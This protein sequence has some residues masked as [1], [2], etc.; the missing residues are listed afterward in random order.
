MK[1]IKTLS[2]GVVLG[3]GAMVSCQLQK[4]PAPA[5]KASL[6][7]TWWCNS[8]QVLPD[9]YFGADGD[10]KQR[11][12]GEIQNGRWRMSDDSKSILI[13]D[14][15]PKAEGTWSYGLKDVR[16]DQIVFTFYGA[17]NSFGKCQ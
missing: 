4:D 15:G 10:F 1:T 16:A 2:W 3:V 7:E 9:Q 14:F 8:Q 12:K 17:D 13:S 6:T 11:Q 5:I